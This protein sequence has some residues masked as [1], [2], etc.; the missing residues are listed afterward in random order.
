MELIQKQE[1]NLKW[2]YAPH[3]LSM[4][5]AVETFAE[6]IMRHVKPTWSRDKIRV[7]NCNDGLGTVNGLKGVYQDGTSKE[8][9]GNVILLRVNGEKTHLFTNRHKEMIV[10][11]TLHQL[12]CNPPLY[13]E[14]DNG[15]VYGY[16]AGRPLSYDDFNNDG[17][18][19]SVMQS[20]TRL[21]T[22]KLPQSIQEDHSV[23]HWFFDNWIPLIPS[24]FS[25]DIDGKFRSTFI[26]VDNIKKEAED[27]R[28]VLSTFTSP[29]VYCH[30][31]LQYGNL[32]YNQ[33]TGV[34]TIIDHEYGG[35]NHV[36]CELGDLFGE[37]AGLDI[38]DYTRYPDEPTQKEIIRMYLDNSTKMQV[39]N[40]AVNELYVEVNKGC[41]VMHLV[42]TIWGLMQTH[43]SGLDGFNYLE[44]V[45]HRY[46]HYLQLKQIWLK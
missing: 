34:T 39:S 19:L 2:L 33:R 21:H 1:G 17:I 46:S 28:R 26:S 12:G 36:S 25:D 22:I 40:E 13:V 44:Y 20:M 3:K 8:E 30:N 24:K 32:I 6:S 42:W 15:I 45:T 23:V 9:D 7:F 18:L 37:F 43:L 4:D 5:N 16:V 31:D 29:L 41:M 27:M 10:M 35:L 38:P 14:F 11:L